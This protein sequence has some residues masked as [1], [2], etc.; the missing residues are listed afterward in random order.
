MKFCFLSRYRFAA[1]LLSAGIAVFMP[2]GISLAGSY[3]V[4]HTFCSGGTCADGQ[5]SAA[6]L[7]TDASGN[8][9]G[10]AAL[11]GDAGWGTI[12]EFVKRNGGYR[13]KRLHSFCSKPNCTD[14]SDPVAGLIADAA[15]N[16]YGT[17]KFG[18]A[19]NGGAAFELILSGGKKRFRVL[20]SFC[21]QGAPCADG[22]NPVYDGLAYRGKASGQ[23][24]DG[25]SPLY[26]T[27][28]YGGENNGGFSG[29]V[30]RLLPVAGKSKW[31]E[32][33][34]YQFCA[35][36][37]CADG[38]QPYNGLTVDTAGNLFGVTFG[39]GSQGDGALF[40]LSQ[41]KR[42]WTET[43]LHN[44]CTQANCADGSN[45]EAALAVDGSGDLIGT[46]TSGGANG[47][48]VVFKVA[49]N[50]SNYGVLYDFC[51]QPNCADGYNP[52]GALAIDESGN[53]FGSN[54]RGGDAD[55][56]GGVLYEL[57]DS[58]FSVLYTFCSTGNCI[59]GRRSVGG[60]VRDGA[61]DLFGTTTLGGGP[62]QGV[63]YELTP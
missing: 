2:A 45:P 44:F 63:V 31:K 23:P 41:Q 51:A 60:P 14:G 62:D 3:D 56:D 26:G 4:L 15:G 49:A 12:F 54:L 59:A 35:Q 43:V 25:A 36:A 46:T 21:A 9:Y 61:G 22:S 17:T 27:T 10:T 28:I 55:N 20:H 1:L 30:Y 57:S 24:Y 58:T 18:G 6:P 52:I 13:F 53:I 7:V 39:G 16:L 19:Q 29:V 40:R 33:V 8:F 42:N 50:N 34:L 47:G 11:G 37:N 32:T 5:Y 48:G 38:S